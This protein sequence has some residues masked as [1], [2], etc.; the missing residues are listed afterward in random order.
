MSARARPS[1]GRLLRPVRG[2]LV[3]VCLLQAVSAVAGVAPFAAVSEL[4]RV[5]LA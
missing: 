4:A 2:V 5:L 3:L 1:L